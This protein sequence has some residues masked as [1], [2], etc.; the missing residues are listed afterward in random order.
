MGG[1]YRREMCAPTTRFTVH[2]TVGAI[3]NS[4]TEKLNLSVNPSG[5]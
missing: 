2:L 1:S 4:I 5:V 3:S